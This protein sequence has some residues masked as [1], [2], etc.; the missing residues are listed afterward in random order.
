M[1]GQTVT[2]PLSEARAAQ[3]KDLPG[4]LPGAIQFTTGARSPTIG[5]ALGHTRPAS[6]ATYGRGLMSV[7]NKASEVNIHSMPVVIVVAQQAGT[8]FARYTPRIMS[9][10]IPVPSQYQ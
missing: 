4:N 9:N 1:Y 7:S 8:S 6:A 3:Q 10:T 2:R 5:E